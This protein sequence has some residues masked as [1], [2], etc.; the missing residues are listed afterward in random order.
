MTSSRTT[1]HPERYP[2]L[3][4]ESPLYD[5]LPTPTSIRVLLL[6]PGQFEDEICCFFFPCDLD[7]DRA[8]D[9]TSPRPFK[10]VSFAKFEV[11]GPECENV[12][13]RFA[14]HIDM[15]HAKRQ[16]DTAFISAVSATRHQQETAGNKGKEPADIPH[17][18]E[19]PFSEVAESFATSS[20]SEKEAT[21]D[22]ELKSYS[23]L[24]DGETDSDRHRRITYQFSM[25]YLNTNLIKGSD[26]SR[27]AW[28]RYGE[29]FE[30]W[31]ARFITAEMTDPNKLPDLLNDADWDL[32]QLA[33]GAFWGGSLEAHIHPF[34]RFAALSYV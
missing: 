15:Y 19:Q 34:Q 7:K 31:R 14:F 11:P 30:A 29:A 25:Q 32:L 17:D 5:P 33:R 23:T 4:P 1:I 26:E 24:A 2:K 27:L 9:P 21:V 20:M 3:G 18:V 22:E 8:V 16:E 13:K 12:E 28:A 10:R 6:A